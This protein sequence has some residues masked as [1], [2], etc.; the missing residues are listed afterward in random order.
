MVANYNELIDFI[1]RHTGIVLN[2]RSYVKLSQL[3]EELCASSSAN[4]LAPQLERTS[5]NTPLWQSIIQVLT[6]GETYFFRNKNHIK[7]LRTEILPK[8][9]QEARKRSFKQLR[10]WSAGCAT[11][12]EPYTIAMLLQELL[13]DISEW[14]ITILATDINEAYLAFAKE[15]IYSRRSFRGE[16]EEGIKDKWFVPVKDDAV[17]VR[18]EIKQKVIFS[19]K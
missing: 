18:P 11:G 2:E 4:E 8:L 9:I 5:Y 6:V 14:S 3:L 16:T 19:T 7:A 12:E 13:Y 10:I 17:K 15:G 1:E